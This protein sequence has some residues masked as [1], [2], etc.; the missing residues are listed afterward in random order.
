MSHL[1]YNPQVSLEN[2]N[3]L[4][5]LVAAGV[6]PSY[7]A[8]RERVAKNYLEAGLNDVANFITATI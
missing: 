3:R 8:V 6:E 2:A 1:Y 5:D 7:D 4:L